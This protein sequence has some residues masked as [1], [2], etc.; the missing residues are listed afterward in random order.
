MRRVSNIT[1]GAAA[2]QAAVCGLCSAA[3][4][5]AAMAMGSPAV[6]GVVADA[7]GL[8]IYNQSPLRMAFETDPTKDVKLRPI[9]I[10]GARNGTFSGKVVV[11]S[12]GPVADLG[13]EV[14]DLRR[15]GGG[16]SIAADRIELYNGLITRFTKQVITFD[17]L[18]PPP[19]GEVPVLDLNRFRRHWVNKTAVMGWSIATVWVVVNVPEGAV[20]G[21][22]EGLL[23]VSAG[24]KGSAKVPIRLS[25]SKW[26][27][28]DCRDWQTFFE[29]VQSP[30]SVALYY[31]VPL[32]S[33]KHWELMAKS[34][35]QL[36]EVGHKT[37]YLPLIC[38]TNHGNAESMVRWTRKGQGYSYDL[39][40]L[41][42]YVDTA[43]KAGINPRFVSLWVWDAYLGGGA[44]RAGYLDDTWHTSKEGDPGPK[45]TLLDPKSGKTGTFALPDYSEPAKALPLW[46]PLIAQVKALLQKKGLW[47]KVVWGMTSDKV[48]TAETVSFFKSIDPGIP[49]S[50]RGHSRFKGIHGVPYALQVAP[51]GNTFSYSMGPG[52]FKYGWQRVDPCVEVGFS[53]DTRNYYARCRYRMISEINIGGNQA[54][55]GGWGGDSWLSMRD[56]R[57]RIV[58]RV[59]ENRYPASSWRNVSVRTNLLHPGKD[60]ALPTARFM[61]VREG[62]QECEARTLIEKAVVSGKVTGALA[63]RC[64]SLIDERNQKLKAE[65]PGNWSYGDFHWENA[66]KDFPSFIDGPW[67]K[68]SRQLFDLA[69]EIAMKVHPASQKAATPRPKPPAARSSRP[70]PTRP[71]TPPKPRT[72][73]EKLSSWMRM[74]RSAKRS[75][76][77]PL[78][79]SYLQRILKNAPAASSVRAEAEKMLVE[80]DE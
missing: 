62:L 54:G 5:A 76:A 73:D 46:K 9:T 31:Q 45:V 30:D 78:A 6:A 21:E 13:A 32:W 47:E 38:E 34:F 16:G 10:V 65:M 28:P 77:D 67:Q 59:T 35:E 15:S 12:K 42:K 3:L 69:Y 55:H 14:T 70:A 2:L 43:L 72:L 41:E 22:Y 23:K 57:G 50:R 53:R 1:T 80:I 24:G 17:N 7:A 36:A 75:G 39:S 27:V 68:R 61:M 66:K 8:R 71:R 4:A 29:L 20:P 33:E 60:G 74:A 52:E 51:S 64:R 44:V 18:V 26:K 49:W 19:F 48:P 37:L 63:A 56:K 58:G 25:V 40:I 11:A 79:R